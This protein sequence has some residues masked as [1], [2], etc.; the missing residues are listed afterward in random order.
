MEQPPKGSVQVDASLRTRSADV[1]LVRCHFI[2][3][4]DS[5]LRTDGTFRLELCLTSRHRSARG[6]FRDQW[7]SNRYERIGDLFITPPDLEQLARSD[8][9]TSLAS[10]VCELAPEPLLELFERRPELT[11]EHLRSSLDVRDAK[12][13]QLLLRLAEEARQPGFASD[14]LV[15]LI[16]GQMAIELFRLGG[17]V[18]EPQANGGLAAWQL[19]LIDE[20]L[21]EV[22]EAPTLPVLAELCRISVRQLT[23]GFRTSRGSSL[24]AYVA[25]NQMEHAK[26]LLAADESVTAIAATLGFSSS[27]NFCFAFRRAT[28]MTPGQFRQA[29]LRR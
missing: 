3:P 21:R 26:R 12:V 23:R 27:S 19:R 9:A 18:R 24:G 2:E 16:A 5:V 6:R 4:P 17:A 7:S 29:L 28:G 15:E 13:R 20:R 1:Q 10:I 14:M 11:D 22:R 25:D 8:E